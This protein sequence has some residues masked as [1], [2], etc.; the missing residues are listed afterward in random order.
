[1]SDDAK[2]TTG[3]ATQDAKKFPV[4]LP[5]TDFP[6]KGNLSQLEPRMLA[7][8]EEHQTYPRL[9]KQLEG[10]QPFLF[11]DG[12]PYANGHMHM[13]HALNKVLKDFVV[14]Y[15]CMTGRPVDF[16]PGWDTHG[17]PIEQAVE[18]RLKDKKIDK[19]TMDREAFLDACRDYATEFVA[20]QTAEQQRLGLFARY[21]QPYLTLNPSY[22]AQ[23]IRELAG[24]AKR[25][26]LYR[27][28]KPVYWDPWDQT[29]LAE[30][31]VEYAMLKVP[32]AFVGFPLD[33]A[34]QQKLAAQVPAV[35][36]RKVELLIWTTT[37][38]TL[39]ANLAVSVHP[40]FEYVLYALGERTVLVAKELLPKVLAE[41]GEGELAVKDVALPGG[42]VQAA[43]LADP[44]RVLG[45]VSGADL[46]HLTYVHPLLQDETRRPVILGDHVTLE[47][48]TG[49][50]HTA[51]G[52]GPDD[53][54]V[55]LK[56][57]LEPYSPVN[58]RGAYEA[59]PELEALGLAG[60]NVWA[61][62][63][64]VME[65]LAERG[66]L[67][68]DKDAVLE[69]SYPHGWR[70]H[71]PLLFRATH[72]WF[73]PL[74]Q[75]GTELR[76]A[77]LEEIEKVQWVPSWGKHRIV[78]ML[79][80]RPDWCI[81]RQ[82]TWG[83]P[84]PVA[85]C[86]T[87]GCNGAHVSEDLM[88]KVADAVEKHGIAVWYSTPVTEF[89]PS[90]DFACPDCGQQ[91]WRRETDILDVWFD[92]ACS[93]AGVMEKR[94]G[95]G[96]V[97]LYLEGSDQHRGW[98]HSSLLVSTATRGRAP[99]KTVLTHG[100]VVDGAGEKM[101]KSKGNVVAP[102]K[103]INQYG[104]EVVRL[105][106][107][108]TDYRNDVRLGDVILKGLSEGYRKI[109][110]TLRYALSNLYDFDPATDAVPVDA[111]Q[112]LD[113]WAR[114]E[115][116]SLVERTRAA[117]EAYEFHL[118]Y[119]AVVDFCSGELSALYFDILKDRLYTSKTDGPL[120]RSAQTVLHEIADTLLRLL[121]P[122]MS[123]T[124]EEAWQ[125][126]PGKRAES[127]FFAGMPEVDATAK[128]AALVERYG[129]LFA[130]R[131]AL[132]QQLLE[133][134]RREKRIGSSLEARVVLA[135]DGAWKELLQAHVDELPALFIVSQ[136]E[137]VD[138]APEGAVALELAGTADAGQVHAAQ[139]EAA[140]EKCPR[141]WTYSTAIDATHELC[142]KCAEAL[143]A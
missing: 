31:E 109:R 16:I 101:S 33:A 92:S 25:G 87:E 27:K 21:D 90:P 112:P 104:A 29:A 9:L 17:L 20:I 135:A 32:S 1:M 134:A 26:M 121:A 82:R 133:P 24:F 66:A 117:Y 54:L 122:V 34:S 137:L 41:L 88:L 142:P 85:L 52:H 95:P 143:A 7:W 108:A 89:L 131:S 58:A 18:K 73:I 44:T 99:Y 118:V 94:F 138:A 53:Y 3:H 84:I 129:K 36:G 116:A 5:K 46:E 60:L 128:D 139:L 72:Q 15:H 68:G 136:V 47:A 125:H 119:A 49:L 126:V 140:G 12:P 64:K 59:L 132:Q 96:K 22:E 115:L 78:G 106:V 86:E 102:E 65:L 40:A 97:D 10:K 113:R 77:G 42:P 124:A 98:F 79:E 14:K 50:V 6:M 107:A 23:V 70:S 28:K 56:Y 11:N 75:E 114:A 127:V 57:G 123:F 76:R 69:T 81:S 2:A 51:P 8:W 45:Y 67:F 110:N 111:L 91:A 39:P 37:P 63:P 30:A 74:D 141:C 55:G 130:V 103:V 80:K 71:K 120:R 93:F 105:W 83:V 4:N 61:A 43:A 19:R 13:G 38:W 48:G 62:N 100:F 35:A